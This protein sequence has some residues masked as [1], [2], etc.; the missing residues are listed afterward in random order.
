[1]LPIRF[2]FPLPRP[3]EHSENPLGASRGPHAL[4]VE[5]SVRGEAVW[6]VVFLLRDA[7]KVS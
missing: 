6:A 4:S 1:M 7:E 5:G 3:Q 2:I